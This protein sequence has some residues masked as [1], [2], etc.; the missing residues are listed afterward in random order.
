MAFCD[1]ERIASVKGRTKVPA[2]ARAALHSA[3]HGMMLCARKRR[4]GERGK[5]KGTDA[6]CSISIKLMDGNGKD[7]HSQGTTC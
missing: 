4:L 1:F 7:K 3:F 5:T 2:K 6:V